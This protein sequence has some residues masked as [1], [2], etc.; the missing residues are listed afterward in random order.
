M[1]A[2]PLHR[3]NAGKVADHGD[4]LVLERQPMS[5]RH[6]VREIVIREAEYEKLVRVWY[7]RHIVGLQQEIVIVGNPQRVKSGVLIG[8]DV[9]VRNS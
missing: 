1:R 9:R 2:V 7:R 3:E 5:G 4:P 8:P 6:V